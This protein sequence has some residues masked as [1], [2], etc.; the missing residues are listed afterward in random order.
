MRPTKP[1]HIGPTDLCCW[2][3]PDVL[4]WQPVHIQLYTGLFF[5]RCLLFAMFCLF[6]CSTGNV[7]GVPLCSKL[8]QA[9]DGVLYMAA[10]KRLNV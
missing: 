7:G 5:P 2:G 3:T 8:V 6:I 4:P 9:K 10:T 1:P